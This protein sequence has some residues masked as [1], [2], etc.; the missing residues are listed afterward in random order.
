MPLPSEELRRR[1]LAQWESA[2]RKLAR[3]RADELAHVDLAA[4]ATALE[5]ACLVAMRERV[6]STTSG[7]VEQQ[8]RW[9]AARR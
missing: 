8:R 2:G 3:V 1:W 9:H 6:K 4:I 5:E 7:L